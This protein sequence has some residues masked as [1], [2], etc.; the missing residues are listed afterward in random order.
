MKTWHEYYRD[1]NK[2]EVLIKY[3]VK[4]P[5][6]VDNFNIDDR[7]LHIRQDG[8]EIHI[9]YHKLITQTL[10][11]DLKEFF[12][13]FKNNKSIPDDLIKKNPSQYIVG[14]IGET[15]PR[16]NQEIL[17]RKYKEGHVIL[18]TISQ[19]DIYNVFIVDDSGNYHAIL[20][21]NPIP[22]FPE[23]KKFQKNLDVVF[24][25]DFIDAM[26]EYF[27]FNLD[28]CVRKVI[29][30]LEN[31][32]IYYNLKPISKINFWTKLFKRKRAKFQ[33]LVNDYITES[34]Y[35]FKERDLK[36]LRENILF[37]YKIR[38]LIVHDK[39]RL[40]LDNLMFCKKAIGTLLYIYQSKFT[41]NDG[42]KDYV[43]AFDMQ[44]K[45]IA[46]MII[47]LNLDNFEKAENSKRKPQIISN[48]DEL[49][50]SMFASLKITK[51][52]KRTAKKQ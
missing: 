38:N 6:K 29:T 19:F 7:P 44:F 20:W 9:N 47:G 24:V 43:F 41:Y 22:G 14:F 35:P 27:Y 52:Q 28:E 45:M 31:Y 50:K 21:P 11:D 26:T 18:K 36:I 13:C 40:K 42:R 8:G 48:D 5:S 25:R 17:D 49:N 46:D 16:I 15:L 4:L 23:V 37:V 10:L 34:H 33:R 30:S 1:K 3:S 12:N 2:K 39:L 32:F 51:K